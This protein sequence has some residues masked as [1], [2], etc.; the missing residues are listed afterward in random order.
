MF[1]ATTC[2]DIRYF[3][4]SATLIVCKQ[5]NVLKL[6]KKNQINFI[7]ACLNISGFM[8]KISLKL[9]IVSCQIYIESVSKCYSKILTQNSMVG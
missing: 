2:I 8:Q 1:L 5:T 6:F 4:E 9:N 7:A 3:L